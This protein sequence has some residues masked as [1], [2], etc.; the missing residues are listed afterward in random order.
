MSP[1]MKE[2]FE[3]VLLN[4]SYVIMTRSYSSGQKLRSFDGTL[5]NDASYLKLY[6]FPQVLEFLAW[7][8]LGCVRKIEIQVQRYEHICTVHLSNWFCQLTGADMVQ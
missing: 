5:L 2:K 8:D 6:C 1:V 7:E 3:A 4:N